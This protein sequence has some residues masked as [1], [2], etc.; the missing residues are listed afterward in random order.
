[1]SLS[2]A[3]HV[4]TACSTV[5]T[6][7]AEIRRQLLNAG[8]ELAAQEAV[9]LMEQ[10]LDLSGL[11][12]IVDHNRELSKQETA[13]VLALLARRMKRE[14]LQYLLGTQEFCGLEFEVNPSVLIPRPETELLVRETIRR[15][16]RGQHPTLV[17]VGTGSGCLA[18]TLARSIPAGKMLAIDLSASAL[19]TA[20]R[21]ADRH[22]VGSAITWLEG[23][24]LAP[25]A[26]RGL[27]GAV[28]VIVSNPPYIRETEWETLQ[29]EVRLYEPRAALIAGPHGT[30]LHERL[31]SEAIPFL[32][33]GGLLI[34]EL[35]QG[36]S[37]ALYERV[38]SMAAYTSAE[39]VL[40]EGGID[41][42]LIVERVDNANG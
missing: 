11:R 26:G 8:I 35:G 3:N 24:L 12:Q 36:Q 23:D 21:N 40:D 32:M 25:L 16:P 1:M 2:A 38:E 9:W 37:A 39:I 19:Q 14:P 18:V 5:G 30:E 20:K 28:T 7:I 27:E 10:A 42:V 33:P 13:E 34:M 17:D 41:R 22:G 15:L 31:L 4:S 29:P 6:L